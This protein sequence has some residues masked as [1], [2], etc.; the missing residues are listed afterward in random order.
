MSVGCNDLDV[1]EG[2]E[3]FASIKSTVE[4][5]K[6]LYP[7]VKVII[8]E[9]TPRMDDLD[10]NVKAV[11][12]MLNEFVKWSDDTFITRNS[13][14]RDQD[15]YYDNK[16][17]KE[18]CI[19]RFA[20]NIKRALRAAYGIVQHKG[21][22]LNSQRNNDDYPSNRNTKILNEQDTNTTF[23]RFKESLLRKITAAF[24]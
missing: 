4:K 18:S 6:S 20:A 10:T 22:N 7:Q 5:V 17:L 15:F 2:N 14:L 1:K 3:V 21:Q 16:H 12:T 11:N 8:S 24:E 13:N 23:N 19:P 9:I